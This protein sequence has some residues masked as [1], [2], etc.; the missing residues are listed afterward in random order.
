MKLNKS[1]LLAFVILIVVAAVSRIMMF[2]IAGFAP[3]MAMALFGGA[4]IKDKKWALALPLFSLLL[5]DLIMHFLFSRGIVERAGFYS[6]QWAVYLCFAVITL[7]GFLLRKINVKNIILFSISGSV[8]FFLLSNFFVWIGGGGFQRPLTFD[9]MLLC[10][11]DALLY[12]RDH[13]LIK[14]FIGNQVLGDLAWSLALFGGYY[15]IS[16]ITFSTSPEGVKE[17]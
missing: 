7:Y 13:G 11:W 5:S 8:L 14:G 6:G 2:N 16:K 4:I 10:Y 12:Y 1:T 15:L 3:Q 9:G 17:M